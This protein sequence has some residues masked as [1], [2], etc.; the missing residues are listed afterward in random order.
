[1]PFTQQ[2]SFPCELH[3]VTGPNGP[4]LY[5]YP[6]KEIDALRVLPDRTSLEVFGNR[7]EVSMTSCLAPAEQNTPLELY[8]EGGEI[9]V[10][11]LTLYRLRPAWG[12][13]ETT[14]IA[15][16]DEQTGPGWWLLSVGKRFRTLGENRNACAAL[17]SA[18]GN[19]FAVWDD[20]DIC[21]P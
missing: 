17:A 8:T 10:E 3:L 9:V 1:M 18:D 11:S 21:L 5:R 4:R 2:M 15:A 16:R 12:P 13:D 7:G 6:V 19:A 14:D 20:D